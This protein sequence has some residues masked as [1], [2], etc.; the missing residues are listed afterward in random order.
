MDWIREPEKMNTT[1]SET[2]PRSYDG[3]YMAAGRA[4]EGIVMAWLHEQPQFIGVES[5]T[6]LRQLREADVDC[7]FSLSDGRVTFAEIK[8][9]RWLGKTGRVLFEVL[10]INHKV[11]PSVPP[12]LFKPKGAGKRSSEFQRSGNSWTREK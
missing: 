8:S 12:S 10:R 6:G 11:P 2:R 4:A 5:L 7:S 1:P 9:D 3:D